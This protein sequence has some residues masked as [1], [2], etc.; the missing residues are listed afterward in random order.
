MFWTWAPDSSRSDHRPNGTDVHIALAQSQQDAEFHIRDLYQKHARMARIKFCIPLMPLMAV[1]SLIGKTP[2]VF[3]VPVVF[4][5][6]Q[7]VSPGDVVLL[8]GGDFRKVVSLSIARLTDGPAGQ[9]PR[10]SPASIAPN[11]IT[12]PALQPSPHSVKFVLPSSLDPGVFEASFGG[13]PLII[14]AP[15]VSWTQQ[16]Y[17]QPGLGE[18][19]A[20]PDSEIEIIGRNFIPEGGKPGDV[21][22]V[23]RDADG[24]DVVLAVS[25]IDKYSIIARLP[26]NTASGTYDLWVHN[27][28]GGTSAWGDG[29]KLTVRLPVQWPDRVFNVRDFG[30][31]GDNITDDSSAVHS[32][33]DAAQRNGGG[34]I[35]FPA[36]TYRLSGWMRIPKRVILRGE[37]RDL[38]WLK[39]RETNPTALSEIVPAVLY[40]NGEYGI[41][42]LTIVARNTQ[43]IL[44]DLSWD[45]AV[46]E[47]KAPLPQLQPLI[48]APGKERD[49]FLRDD[50]F[51]LLYYAGRPSS[52]DHGIR[53]TLNG[54]GW[55][56]GGLMKVVA[57][58]EVRNIEVSDCRFAGGAQFISE[59]R[60]A[61]LVGNRFNNEW[62]PLSWTALGGE[63]VTFERNDIEGASGWSRNLLPI[64]Y[65]YAA[66]NHSSN[67]VSGEREALTFDVNGVTARPG[68]SGWTHTPL[69]AVDAWQGRIQSAAATSLTLTNAHL[70][71]H[72]YEGLDVLILSGTGAGQY[73]E[74]T[75]N[76]GSEVI[77]N[78]PWDVSPDSTSVALIWSL[79]GHCILYRNH[80]EDTSVLFQIWGYLYDCIL[81]GNQVD[82]SQGMWGLSGWFVQWL[83]NRLWVGA[84]FHQGVGPS[85]SP[86]EITPEGGE[87]F[88]FM[89]F[90]IDGA[91]GALPIRFPYV[92]ACIIRG[93]TL[94]YNQRILVMLGYGGARQK[95][96][97]TAAEDLVIDRNNIR[98][99]P[100]GIEL[101]SNIAGCALNANT[102]TAITRPYD[103]SDS[104]ECQI[105]S[106]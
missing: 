55:G 54:L 36:G 101:D 105:L 4:W 51:Q 57:I 17:L 52:V 38:S 39:W 48:A 73:R 5:I 84:T 65:V 95:A 92:R 86:P 43:T 78:A 69:P 67:I 42:H 15:Q 3:P 66:Y 81:D 61:R 96:K 18:N 32:A 46:G 20:S 58:G 60:N 44:R 102:F 106:H 33:F 22:A 9:P 99:G 45:S 24:R 63:Y 1:L 62:A 79:M 2:A 89:G 94:A 31:R 75:D 91:M 53:S 37:R 80:A 11:G 47:A 70:R 93:N 21:R 23:L 68:E 83:N 27:G 82:R 100:V 90:A 13:K 12:V 8:Y 28:Y 14:G 74:I 103:L 29:A 56:N 25:H 19:E 98:N 72:V 7:P 34:V 16:T 77:V 85:G 87:P 49:V 30:A 26:P 97:F 71:P 59:S 76:T 35:Y 88:G 50:D 6:S 41:E 64:R 104:Q 40:G 10:Q